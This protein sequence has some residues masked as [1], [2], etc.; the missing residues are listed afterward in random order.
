MKPFFLQQ[1]RRFSEFSFQR[2]PTIDT[3]IR[4]IFKQDNGSDHARPL[5]IYS[6]NNAQKE[7]TVELK[8]SFGM[9]EFRKSIYQAISTL[10]NNN[11]YSASMLVED[12]PYHLCKTSKFDLIKNI[13]RITSFTSHSFNDY[14]SKPVIIFFRM[15]FGE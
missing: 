2:Q 10:Q 13:M 11:I 12:L 4:F 7:L 5:L 9:Y 15:C 1:A 6:N 14:K 8:K 3:H